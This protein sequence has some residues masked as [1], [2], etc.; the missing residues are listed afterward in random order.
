MAKNPFIKVRIDPKSIPDKQ[1]LK[2]SVNKKI[3]QAINKEMQ[4]VFLESQVLVPVNTGALKESG[5]FI[6]AQEMV[7]D[8]EMPRAYINYGNEEVDYAVY[9]H[10]ELENAH[11]APT[12][13]KY[14]EQPLAQAQAKILMAIRNASVKGILN[15]WR[16]RQ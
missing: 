15:G 3:A 2:S 7:P 9:V 16:R 6:P 4:K 13:A 8:G 11:E 1:L 14:L 10:E 12:Q 5:V